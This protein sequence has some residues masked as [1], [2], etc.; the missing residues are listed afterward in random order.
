M[1]LGDEKEFW[2]LNNKSTFSC[3]LEN[4]VKMK[5]KN[6]KMFENCAIE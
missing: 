3:L 4:M 2:A 5:I 1:I 6:K